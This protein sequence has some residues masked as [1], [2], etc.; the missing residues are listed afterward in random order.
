VVRPPIPDD[1]LE[2]HQ[3][4]KEEVYRDI[5]RIPEAVRLDE[6]AGTICEGRICKITSGRKTAY[7]IVRGVK[8]F[9]LEGSPAHEHGRCIHMDEATRKRLGVEETHSA[10]FELE[11]CGWWG[12]FRWAWNAT[13]IGYRISSRLGLLGL[14]LGLIALFPE[15]VKWVAELSRW[16]AEHLHATQ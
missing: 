10:R 13:E 15:L 11:P 16:I 9:E 7:V 1:R 8:N 3:G 12:E 14:V 6:A 5:V 2:I 4:K